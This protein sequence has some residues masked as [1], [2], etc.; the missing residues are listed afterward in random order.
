M[1]VRVAVV[2]TAIVATWVGASS[3]Q[4][5]TTDE[6][7]GGVDTLFA[8]PGRSPITYLTTYDRDV[9]TGTWTQSIS[10]SRARPRVLLGL[11]GS[12]NR[13]AFVNGRGLGSGNGNFSGRLSLL[14]A[15]GLT[16]G[17]NGR[18]D[19]IASQDPISRFTQRQNR[20]MLW[21]T[22]LIV[23]LRG[24][25]MRAILTS[26]F[27]Q[28]HTLTLRPLA[29]EKLR[30]F[31]SYNAA[32]D[33][34]GVDSIFV[35]DQRDSTYMTGRQDGLTTQANWNPS[36]WLRVTALGAGTRIRPTTTNNLRDIGRSVGQTQAEHRERTRYESPNE[37]LNYETKVAY[38][39][40]RG[41]QSWI[42]LSRLRSNQ[43]YFDKLSRAQEELSYELDGAVLHA[44]HSPLRSVQISLD[45]KLDR[46]LSD[47]RVRTSRT[48]LVTG[49]TMKGA[50]T[51]NPSFQTR[52][53]LE[54]DLD[55]HRNARQ[56]SGNGLNTTHFLQM[57]GAHRLT[58]R[59]GMD[60]VSTISLTS[61]EYENPIL[62]EDNLRTYVNVGGGYQVSSRC[63]TTVHF[64]TSRGH[65]IAIDPTQSGNN[66]IQST[67]QMDA[68]LRLFVTPSVNINQNYNL[69]AFYQIYD[70]AGAE[71]KNV[72]SRI[73]RID[74]VI[75][76][77]LFP[78]AQVQL[79]H[80]FLY[81]DTGTFRRRPGEDVRKYSIATRMYQQTLSAS[82]ILKPVS[83]ID[84]FLIQ[85]LGNTTTTIPASLTTTIDTRWNLAL[86]ANIDRPILGDAELKG[87]VQHIAGYTERRDL[88][89][90]FHEQDDWYVAASLLKPF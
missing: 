77:S 81:F 82:V 49:K 65:R 12:S 27:Q 8:H 64:S 83:G 19:K 43:Q 41:L 57:S 20:L 71:S 52:A 90:P 79:K 5:Q 59:F 70:D 88:T 6:L 4:A 42:K 30:Y 2:L 34:V 14:A 58:A 26:E 48:S 25:D 1:R 23:P 67:Y 54:F 28:D 22:Y 61:R 7:L 62:D 3:V 89:D 68:T 55:E 53:A 13:T 38:T 15:K 74:T 44:E 86:G 33:S 35:R 37:Y 63:S 46:T 69:N 66:N 45:G 29:Q 60:G 39:G 80:N 85:S 40:P 75:S 36:R 56:S 76:D 16:V 47:Y 17:A 84:L 24:L 72:L 51:Y 9:S 50:L 87:T 31:T 11:D 21:S 32:G 73:R 18:F 10:Y 78:F